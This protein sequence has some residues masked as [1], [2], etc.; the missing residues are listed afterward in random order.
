[1][2]GLFNYDRDTLINI[3]IKMGI[4]LIG[5]AILFL[6]IS[7][8]FP[9]IAVAI[10]FVA[11]LLLPFILAWLLSVLTQ[12]LV[13]FMHFKMHMPRGASVLLMLLILFGVISVVMSLIVSRVVLSFF[14]LPAYIM[15]LEHNIN[16]AFIYLQDLYA[17]INLN[18]EEIERIKEWLVS[19]SQNVLQFIY[20]GLGGAVNVISSLPT[21]IIFLLITLVAVF[22]WCRDREIIQSAFVAL[23]PPAKRQRMNA[24]YLSFSRIIGKYCRAQMLLIS[25]STLLAIIA[26]SILGV[27]GAISMGLLTGFFDILPVLGP[28]TII[29]P[30]MIWSFIVKNYFMGFGLLILYAVLIITRNILEPKLVGD[31]LGIHP[32]AVLA[33]IFIGLQLFGVW[34][35]FLGPISLAVGA[36]LL[37]SRK[38]VI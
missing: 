24:L 35:V 20:Q 30:W 13:D 11:F 1:M 14:K 16:A 27:E 5:L 22:F 6:L 7:F 12:P 8:I 19:V 36:A 29:I 2:K 32:L 38:K 17:K 4:V 23:A 26:Y 10:P 31:S 3:L 9:W 34:G 18:P 28:G 21:G 33:A 37:Y 15:S 25:I